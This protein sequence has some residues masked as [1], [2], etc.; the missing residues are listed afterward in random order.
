MVSDL[1]GN[2]AV[3]YDTCVKNVEKLKAVENVASFD[4]MH[5]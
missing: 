4:Y 2:Y 3:I 5:T 1:R